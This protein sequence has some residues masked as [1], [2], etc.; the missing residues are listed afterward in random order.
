MFHRPPFASLPAVL[1]IAL[2]L[3][4]GVL[5]VPSLSSFSSPQGTAHADHS[6][7]PTVSIKAVMPEVGEEGSTV[8]VTLKLSRQLTDDEKFCYHVHRG[9][10][11]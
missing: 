3:V 10:A 7:R 4:M 1:T 11:I 9:N 8:T 2:I 6:S 5:L